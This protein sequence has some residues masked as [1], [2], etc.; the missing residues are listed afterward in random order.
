MSLDVSMPD[1]LVSHRNPVRDAIEQ[2]ELHGEGAIP[3]PSF[4]RQYVAVGPPLSRDDTLGDDGL[5]LHDYT[6]RGVAD[7]V[8]D[9]LTQSIEL[10]RQ[11]KD[12]PASERHIVER[13]LTEAS[14]NGSAHGVVVHGHHDRAVLGDRR[15]ETAAVDE[16]RADRLEVFDE[17][18]LMFW[19]I[20]P[21]NVKPAAL[22]ISSGKISIQ[23]FLQYPLERFLGSAPG[24]NLRQYDCALRA[25]LVR[26]NR[27]SRAF[28]IMSLAHNRY[29]AFGADAS[30]R[31]FMAKLKTARAFDAL[32]PHRPFEFAS[33]VAVAWTTYA[34][35]RQIRLEHAET[36]RD[37]VF[38]WHVSGNLSSAI[39]AVLHT[40]A[41]ATAERH[42]LRE[43]R[44]VA[45]G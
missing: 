29:N 25:V 9:E 24:S 34:T 16:C 30:N 14:R 13:D 2:S 12:I 44:H 42:P 27:S 18:L 39:D 6:P 37:Y 15:L 40:S 32:D 35:Q 33:Q 3:R 26:F 31:S 28:P 4:N 5:L 11:R 36:L 43:H 23:I 19:P 21:D 38:P 7:I 41:R 45:D 10:A 1:V 20:A 17:A 8:A 22:W